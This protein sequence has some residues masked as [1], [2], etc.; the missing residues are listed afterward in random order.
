MVVMRPS[1]ILG[2]GFR[3]TF[4]KLT[5]LLNRSHWQTLPVLQK[6]EN[7]PWW[8]AQDTKHMVL[9]VL[10]FY[11]PL[12]THSMVGSL[13]LMVKG[14]EDFEKPSMSTINSSLHTEIEREGAS[15][16]TFP[17]TE[18]F[19]RPP[20]QQNVQSSCTAQRLDQV[21][22]QWRKCS[23]DWTMKRATNRHEA[24]CSL[25]S[26]LWE[27][28]RTFELTTRTHER[29]RSVDPTYAYSENRNFLEA[30]IAL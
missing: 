15:W 30:G 5:L 7:P 24:L 10:C 29:T 13:I 8:V 3:L 6:T 21:R 18:V 28:R 25:C 26:V 20:N 12:M 2:N 11:Y 19:A 4:L 22:Q 27:F 9:S 17:N 23:E 14:W 1:L 16:A